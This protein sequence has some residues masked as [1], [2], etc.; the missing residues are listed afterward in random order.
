MLMDG[1]WQRNNVTNYIT[2][3]DF[4]GNNS[5]KR[6]GLNLRKYFNKEST[7]TPTYGPMQ[8][9]QNGHSL[10]D[11]S[12]QLSAVGV[13]DGASDKSLLLGNWRAGFDNNLTLVDTTVMKN[14]TAA[15]VYRVVTV[16]VR[17]IPKKPKFYY[18][19]LFYSKNRSS[20]ATR[21]LLK[22]FG[23]TVSI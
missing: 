23:D 6:I 22:D 11:F 12:M 14:Y 7:E 17:K 3:D 15:V 10:M 8:I 18:S 19:F 16:V 21:R 4:D 20:T 13:R 9:V 2:C 5:P 1:A